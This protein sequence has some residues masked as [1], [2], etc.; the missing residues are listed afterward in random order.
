M[1][2]RAFAALLAFVILGSLVLLPQSGQAAP[3]SPEQVPETR[4]PFTARFYEETGHTARN[5]FH[6]FWQNTPNALFVLGY[7][8]SEPF[9]E[10]SFTNPGE[11]YRV[12]YFE[13]GVLEEHPDNYGTPFY[14]QGRLMGNE[15]IKGRESEEPFQEV[16]DPGNGTY[17][18]VTGHTLSNSPAPFRSFWQNNGGLAVF[19]RPLSEQ[20]QE[21]NEADGET[22]WVQYFERQRME[23]HPEEADPQYRVLL[24]LLGN[25]YRDANHQA[26]TAFDRTSGPVAEQ[27]SGNFA[28][29]FNAIL[30]GQG[31]PWQDRQRVLQLSK[32]A[33]VYWIRQQIRWMDLHDRS[34]QIFWGELDQIV[35]DADSEGVNLL[36]S[37]VAS[38]SW[39]TA[40]G[41]NGLPSPEHFDDFNYFMGEM[42]ERYEG[43]VQAYQ[44]WNE[45]NLAWENGGR[46]ASADLY[47]DVLVGASQAIKAADPDALV[48][49]G[50]PASTETNRADIALSDITFARQ[51]FADPRFREH[52]DIMS[53]H[54][55]GASN[56]P[57]TMW[58]DNPG[59][60]PNFVT[61][62]E[63]YF[64]RVEDIRAVMVQQGLS[65][66]NIWI[67]EFGWAT[68]NNTPGYEFGNNISFDE[69]A[70]W[71]VEAFQMGSREYDYI[72][73][74]FLWQLN[75]AVPW[76]YEGN[77]LHEQASYGVING[78]WSPRPSYYAIQ[79]MPKD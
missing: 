50:G 39:A 31:S 60:G 21:V 34:G 46:V 2:R 53:V 27:P 1:F 64:R 20:F 58:P 37:V 43:R 70:A 15:I 19:G 36:F 68:R 66:M 4:P 79:G 56:P 28:Y 52:V 55:G 47:M 78:D 69:Q 49:A 22:Y 59:P 26:N 40:N 11:Y 5:S 12:Q 57:R 44:I 71:V 24:G 76:R 30:Y 10:E 29:G 42:A 45:Q 6:V 17:D 7:P 41:R 72:T 32:N 35:A 18:S 51:M 25:E 8:I 75:F 65:D 61:S 74:M 16:A 48:V 73:G 14:I 23:W 67:T 62:R 3:S 63:F 9:I 13:R 33:G 54:P 38:P 77:E